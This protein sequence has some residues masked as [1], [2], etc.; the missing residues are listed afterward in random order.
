[1]KKFIVFIAAVAMVGAFAFTAVAAE[2]SFYGSSRM[3]TMSYDKSKEVTGTAFS[4]QDTTWTMQT[5]ARLGAKVKAE[6]V[7]GQFEAAMSSN[8]G[9]G[10]ALRLMYG[11]WNFG[12]GTLLIGQDYT[13]GDTIISASVGA[14][15][16]TIG[17]TNPVMDGEGNALQIG[18]MYTS[19][20]NQAKLIFGGFQVAF[21]QPSTVGVQGVYTDIDTT[22][23]KIEMSYKFAT[24]MFSVMPYLGYNSVTF[25]NP[26]NDTDVSIDSAILGVT[27]GLNFGPVYVKGNVYGATNSGNYGK[28]NINLY[29]SA[30]ITGGDTDDSDEV[31]GIILVGFK[32]SDMLTFEAGFATEKAERTV[33]AVDYEND[34][35]HW[36]VNATITV[37]PGVMIVPEVG[38]FNFGDNTVGGVST[39]RGDCTYYGA[40]WQI[41]F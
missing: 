23:P 13:P 7:G 38:V 15:P 2:W 27:F 29:D 19:R 33:A 35:S 22:F 24:D 11:T 5:N 20:L 6:A 3:S 31:G 26:A 12:P 32:L 16:S 8:S 10:I 28:S 41:N 18:S 17:G 40:K 39:D 1:M 4:D 30:V 37:A 14:L 21:V 25:A 34:P 9:D 36:Y